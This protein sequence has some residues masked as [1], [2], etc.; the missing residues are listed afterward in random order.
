MSAIVYLDGTARCS[1]SLKSLLNTS[2]IGL[3]PIVSQDYSSL[4]DAAVANGLA[5]DLLGATE[6]AVQRRVAGMR[7]NDFFGGQMEEAGFEHIESKFAVVDGLF[8]QSH[9]SRTRPCRRQ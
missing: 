3:L 2:M 7:V 1:T 6:A 4:W 8:A 5:A 9:A